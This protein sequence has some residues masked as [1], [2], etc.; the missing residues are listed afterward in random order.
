M[1]TFEDLNQIR[2]VLDKGLYI[3]IG[4]SFGEGEL[5]Q[6]YFKYRKSNKRPFV[7]SI[8]NEGGSHAMT[9]IKYNNVKNKENEIEPDL[10]QLTIKNSWGNKWGDKGTIDIL[11]SELAPLCGKLNWVEPM[12]HGECSLWSTCGEMCL[13]DHCS[14]KYDVVKSIS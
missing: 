1:D 4:V 10:I 11:S 9:V 12:I 2:S 13:P 7:G 8:K 14:Q 5:L 3:E 6:K